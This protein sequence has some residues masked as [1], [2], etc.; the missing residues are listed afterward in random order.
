MYRTTNWSS[1]TVKTSC[2]IS[3]GKIW[4]GLL[5]SLKWPFSLIAEHSQ[6]FCPLSLTLSLFHPLF[7][8]GQSIY[9]DRYFQYLG[10]QDITLGNFQGTDRPTFTP[11]NWSGQFLS[12]T[13]TQTHTRTYI[14]T[15][16]SIGNALCM[17]ET[18][19]VGQEMTCVHHYSIVSHDLTILCVREHTN[20]PT[21]TH[22]R[23]LREFQSSESYSAIF[24]AK[25][26]QVI[27]IPSL[28]QPSLH[29]S[30]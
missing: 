26:K 13:Y 4:I 17:W 9:I 3:T 29:G 15:R 30:S 21:K 6:V 28:H 18:V 7:N 14:H 5:P 23:P 16:P 27:L 1:L 24:S 25:W 22:A 8:V 20:Q 12:D 11:W 2:D 10:P 19:Q